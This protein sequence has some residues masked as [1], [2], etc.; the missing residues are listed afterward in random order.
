M[1]L[2]RVTRRAAFATLAA[3]AATTG[4][5][6]DRA[7][8]QQRPALDRPA[9]IVV[10]FPPGGSTD[11]VARLYAERLRGRYAPQVIVENRAGAGGRLGVEAVESM[12]NRGGGDHA[13]L[14]VAL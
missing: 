4:V 11:T 8:A 1:D 12:Q 13:A 2:N 3:A 5:R 10:G 7:A 6:G 9:R 14:A